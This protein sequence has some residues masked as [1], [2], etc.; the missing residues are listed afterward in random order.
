MDSSLDR[1]PIL[2]PRL[3]SVLIPSLGGGQLD[4]HPSFSFFL[5]FIYHLF[6]FDVAFGTKTTLRM[7]LKMERCMKRRQ[8]FA[9]NGIHDIWD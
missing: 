3:K 7:F 5:L 1:C 4:R 6:P 9:T 2:P 8:D